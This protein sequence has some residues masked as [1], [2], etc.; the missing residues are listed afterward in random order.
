MEHQGIAEPCSFCG[1]HQSDRVEH[2]GACTVVTI[3]AFLLQFIDFDQLLDNW[4][5][6]WAHGK[7][8][9]SKVYKDRTRDLLFPIFVTGL[10]ETHNKRDEL[11]WMVNKTSP[12]SVAHPLA[13][14]LAAYSKV[15]RVS[16][17][18]DPARMKRLVFE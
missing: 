7:F 15:Q 13:C 8:G 10:Y 17:R 18:L 16:F 1:A 12:L 2:Y 9:Q 6:A 14:S 5:H 4:V 11:P 3:A